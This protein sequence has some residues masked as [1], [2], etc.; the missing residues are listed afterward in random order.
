MTM[1]GMMPQIYSI[2]WYIILS[3]RITGANNGQVIF[4]SVGR[5]FL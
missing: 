3:T 2:R 5:C 1:D 4:S